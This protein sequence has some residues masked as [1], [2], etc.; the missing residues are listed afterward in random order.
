MKRRNIVIFLIVFL[1]L[2]SSFSGCQALKN[3]TNKTPENYT[4][5]IDFSKDYE[6]DAL[7][8]YDGAIVFDELNA[9][10]EAVIFCGTE[11][12]FEDIVDFY[13]EFFEDNEITLIQEVEE[14]DE[15]YAHGE[16]EG[17]EFKLK[18]AEPDG[19]YV[20][21]LFENII[22]MMTRELKE[23]ES[24][25]A[26]PTPLPTITPAPTQTNDRPSQ[27]NEATPLPS[28]N[29]D[30]P[31]TDGIETR[32]N[33]S[34]DAGAWVLYYDSY[35][36]DSFWEWTI[37]LDDD[38]SGTMYYVDYF[39]GDRWWDDFTYTVNDGIIAFTFG[40]G[41]TYTYF[42]YFDN[43][44][45]HLYQYNDF[46]YDYHFYNYGLEDSS[47]YFYATGDWLVFDSTDDFIGTLAFWPDGIGYVYNWHGEYID[48]PITW[49]NV[50]GTIYFYDDIGTLLD[51]FTWVNPYNILEYYSTTDADIYRFYSR[52]NLNILPGTYEMTY[53]TE[54]NVYSWDLTLYS[55][56]YADI[57]LDT[58][59]G[60]YEDDTSYWYISSFDG[61][62]YLYMNEEYYGFNYHHYETGL[63]FYQDEFDYYYY[64]DLVD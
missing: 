38:Y 13:K 25:M 45:L 42:A 58:S 52:T 44:A 8:I 60:T 29:I 40:N 50:D 47:D 1:L 55:D 35:N 51:S 28:D 53:T 41:D 63:V 4:E 11:D 3:L 5:G 46:D 59:E 6:E 15:Y 61:K 20:E 33:A 17:Y 39:Y 37:Y 24:L 16:F 56:N 31:D 23:G 57:V 62:L 34:P 7:E 2:S 32:L 64:F 19:E 49:E 27:T 22:T 18:V 9:F 48:M 26:T 54:E 10:G 36:D 12:D 30:R 14:R 21:D 43:E